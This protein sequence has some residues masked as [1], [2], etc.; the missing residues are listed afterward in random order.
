MGIEI[1]IAKIP[2]EMSEAKEIRRQVFQ[3]EQGI[4][5]KLDFDGKDEETDLIVAYLGN[6]AV[7]TA[8]VRYLSDNGAKLER[9]AVLKDYRKIG[10]GRK[11]MDY[12]IGYL[13]GKGIKNITLD[14]QEHAKNFYE[15][16][17]FAQEGEIFKEAG[18][19]HIKMCKI[20]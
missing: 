8:R 2:A 17:G 9:L 18:I 12:V 10:L 11:I 7:G 19:P 5:C 4:D 14:A 6:K 3:I 15:K 20:I 16:L 13:K 1:K